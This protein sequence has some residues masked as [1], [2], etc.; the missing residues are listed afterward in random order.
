MPASNTHEL[1]RSLIGEKIV[2]VLFDALP[3]GR[4]DLQQ[5]T[6]TLI[7][8]GGTGITVNSAGAFWGESA[9]EITR[10]VRCAERE[11]RNTEKQLRGV[12]DVAGVLASAT[13]STHAQ[14]QEG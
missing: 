13:S 1:I 7:F 5:G 4:A 12:L 8:E 10:A 11:L 9:D 2:G 3:V 6:W 14:E